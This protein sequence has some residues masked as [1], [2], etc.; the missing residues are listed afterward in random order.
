LIHIFK[1]RDK[2]FNNDDSSVLQEN[3]ICYLVKG[4]N[5]NTITVRSSDCDISINHADEKQYPVHL[6]VDSSNNQ[7][8]IRI[9]ESACAAVILQKAET[10]KT[11][12]EDAGYFISTGRVVEHRTRQYITKE[13]RTKNTV[14]LYRPH[15][16]TPLTA[17]WTGNHRKDVS[18]SL[19]EDHDKHMIKN[20][21]YVLLKRFSS[22][23]EKKRLVA[24]VHLAKMHY[25]EWIGF[26]NKTNY[27]GVLGG[28]LSTIEAYGLAAVLNSSFMDKY[29]RCISGNTQVNATEIR[30]M[31]FPSRDQVKEIGEQAQKLMLFETAK[32]DLIVNPVLGVVD[33]I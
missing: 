22:K 20:G 28:E 12:F 18:F 17:T 33:L 6:I 2:V 21:T 24:S 5:T 19:N 29:F 11:T 3:I 14:P 25:C 31:K 27:I 4:S 13:T 16:V 32:I 9:P 8:L 23:D 30:V 26:G 1:H 10:F 15:N 7:R